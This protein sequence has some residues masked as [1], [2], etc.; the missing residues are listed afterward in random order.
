MLAL[1]NVLTLNTKMWKQFSVLGHYK[2]IN[3]IQNIVNNHDNTLHRF[4]NM[5]PKNFFLD[6]V[7]S[8]LTQ[9]SKIS[10]KRLCENKQH[11]EAFSKGSTCDI[12][13]LAVILKYHKLIQPTL[14][15]ISSRVY[16]VE[17]QKVK[18]PDV[19]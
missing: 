16:A 13:K 5:K 6:H 12:L 3:I 11:R 19:F 9:T 15:L 2:W 18:N 1:L 4:I 14:W 10:W 8:Y 17:L 7:Y